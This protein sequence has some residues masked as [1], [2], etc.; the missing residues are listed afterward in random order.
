M[1]KIGRS[2]YVQTGLPGA[3]T[4]FVVTSEGVVMIESPTVPENAIK[5]RAEI[6][7]FGV[8][9][10]L[11]NTEPHVDHFSGNSFFEG[12]IIGHE[13]TRESILNTPVERLTNLL[14]QQA[15]ESAPLAK[16]FY[17]RPSDI[18]LSERLTLH[19][20]DHTFKLINMPGHSPF[21]VAVYIPEE[22]VVFSSDNVVHETLPYL[23]QALP[24][25][26]LKTLKQIEQLDVD[27]IVP[28]HGTICDRSYLPKMSLIIKAFIDKVTGAIDKGMSLEEAKKTLSFPEFYPAGADP[29]RMANIERMSITH[30][31]EVLK[32]PGK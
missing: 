1:E 28:G 24:Y 23:H 6:A 10:Y 17:F 25:A 8:V 30:L 18:T 20:G 12:I 27:F 16:D 5:W 31:Y 21:Q 7:N 19:L 15:P 3:N 2:V 13:G 4:G 32:I 11:I 9:R 22:R 14:K 26:W 29:E